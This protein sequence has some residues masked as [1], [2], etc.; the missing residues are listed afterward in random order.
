MRPVL[1]SEPLPFPIAFFHSESL[2]RHLIALG[3]LPHPTAPSSCSRG[4]QTFKGIRHKVKPERNHALQA[5]FICFNNEGCMFC[6]GFPPTP[7]Y[8]C[9]HTK[10]RNQAC[11]R[12]PSQELSAAER[13][14]VTHIGRCRGLVVHGELCIPPAALSL[15]PP[16]ARGTGV[17][18]A[19]RGMPGVP[20]SIPG[21]QQ[22]S[23]QPGHSHAPTA[24]L[25]AVAEP[26]L[27]RLH[28]LWLWA[29][30]PRSQLQP[31][32]GSAPAQGLL[33][34]WDGPAWPWVRPRGLG[35]AGMAVAWTRR[36]LVALWAEV[37]WLLAPFPF[38]WLGYSCAIGSVWP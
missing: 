25:A 31:P 9:P 4:C 38:L 6:R 20:V 34:P 16:P 24:G 23:L 29:L 12:A 15:Q 2:S 35:R 10:E 32:R 14:S 26:F 3:G 7:A 19:C 37:L 13:V 27:F 28:L 22:P 1:L 36:G 8:L 17:G 18:L 5:R 11:A 30:P 21:R 33:R